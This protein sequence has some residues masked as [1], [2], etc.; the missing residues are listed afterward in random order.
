MALT[1]RLANGSKAKE[2]SLGV[3]KMNKIRIYKTNYTRCEFEI[4]WTTDF[5]YGAA[6]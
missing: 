1:K 2:F 3:N 6:R 4:H 5:E